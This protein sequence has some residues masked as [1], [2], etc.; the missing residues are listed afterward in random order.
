MGSNNQLFELLKLCK[1]IIEFEKNYQNYSKIA[2]PPD[3]IRD[4][5]IEQI[6]KTEEEFLKINTYYKKIDLNPMQK[7][8]GY[9]Q[10]D[11]FIELHNYLLNQFYDVYIVG[12]ELLVNEFKDFDHR[13]IDYKY[14]FKS[15]YPLNQAHRNGY[16]YTK[17]KIFYFLL[18]ILNKMIIYIKVR[19]KKTKLVSSAVLYSMLL[20][21]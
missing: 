1:S 13:V 19:E 21:L 9:K 11:A 8:R 12:S 7:Q 18:N 4:R 15:L 14:S 3:W 16:I 2:C 20:F 10:T 5:L 6:E 17:D